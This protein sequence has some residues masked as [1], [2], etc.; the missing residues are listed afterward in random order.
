MA[1]QLL[2]N[3]SPDGFDSTQS[4]LTVNGS[5][6]LAG[7]AV[8]TGEP[9]NWTNLMD[10][11]AYT[12]VNYR[13]NGKNG[14]GAAYT[15]G[16]A[17]STGTCTVTANNNFSAGQ[18]V[19]FLGNTGTLSALF[20]NQAPVTILTASSTSFTFSTTNTGTTTTGDVGIA[21]RYVPVQL[22]VPADGAAQSITVSALSA[23]STTLTVTGTNNLLPGALVTVVVATGTLGPKLS[24]LQLPVLNSTGT[25]F[26]AT[27]PS[28]LTGTTGTGTASAVNP[29]QPYSVKFWSTLASGYEYQYNSTTGCLFVLETGA[30]TLSI[31]AGTPATYPVGTAANSGST[32]LVA[33]AAV[34]V[35]LGSSA[36][37]S[38]LPASAYPSGVLAD[39][40]LYEAKFRRG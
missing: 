5:I 18:Q 28:A 17:V 11:I 7:S 33:T 24:G 2:V 20:N 14:T 36:A 27:M 9:I 13:G 29:P 31:G 38:A 6:L 34:T 40:I 22:P 10:A 8:S 26:T 37:L 25:A 4:A 32:T 15:T 16:F 30:A 35:P 39:V 12:Q 23:S 21:V 3:P 19:V 1:S